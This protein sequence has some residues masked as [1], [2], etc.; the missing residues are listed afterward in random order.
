SLGGMWNTNLAP[1][2]RQTWLWVPG[3]AAIGAVV[4]VGWTRLR[5]LWPAFALAGLLL[6]G[7]VGL[8][9]AGALGIPGLRSV[10][11]WVVLNV[12]GGGLLRDSQR[13]L[14]PLA[15]AYAVG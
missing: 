12:P 2:G 1:P 5:R 13:Y 8:L 15:L 11:R 9:A 7:G 14:A 10:Y 4:V 6:A 3:F